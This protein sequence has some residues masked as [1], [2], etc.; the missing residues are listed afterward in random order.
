[1]RTNNIQEI[2]KA[3]ESIRAEKYP[4]IPADLVEKII[5]IE[6]EHQDSRTEASDKIRDLIDKYIK[7]YGG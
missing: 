3:I 6:F 2:V 5:K 4:N 1:M 7:E